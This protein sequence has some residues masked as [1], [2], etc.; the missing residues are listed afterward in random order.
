MKRYDLS[1]DSSKA[2]KSKLMGLILKVKFYSSPV[3]ASSESRLSRMD[4]G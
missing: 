1:Q 4:G 2:F 3:D